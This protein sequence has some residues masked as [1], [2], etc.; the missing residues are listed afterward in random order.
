MPP[1]KENV[2]LQKS[3]RKAKGN[4]GSIPNV[5][6]GVCVCFPFVPGHIAGSV[7]YE[8]KDF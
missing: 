5:E 3:E 8:G 4:W 6:Q 2:K 1:L 7:T